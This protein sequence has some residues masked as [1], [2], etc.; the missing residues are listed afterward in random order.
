MLL[1]VL[2]NLSPAHMYSTIAFHRRAASRWDFPVDT[3]EHWC[4]ATACIV[5]ITRSFRPAGSSLFSGST[6]S[7]W[8]GSSIHS[9]VLRWDLFL[10]PFR[11]KLRRFPCAFTSCYRLARICTENVIG[12]R[13]GYRHRRRMVASWKFKF[14]EAWLRLVSSWFNDILNLLRSLIT[15]V[16]F[17]KLHS[18]YSLRFLLFLLLFAILFPVSKKLSP[19]I[20]R[21]NSE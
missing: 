19:E 10:L 5:S 4:F 15:C 17:P 20:L 11:E 2:T 3:E 6:G 13:F 12:W 9:E 21:T 18:S 1:T 7:I 14:L 16:L 8:S